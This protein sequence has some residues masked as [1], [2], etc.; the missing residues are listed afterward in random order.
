MTLAAKERGG[1]VLA[2][3]ADAPYLCAMVLVA[4]GDFAARYAEAVRRVVRAI[5]DEVDAVAK[6]PLQSAELLGTVGPSLGDPRA[7]IVADPPARLADN[8]SFFGIGGDTPVRYTELYQSAAGLWVK[9]KEP[10]DPF[11]PAESVDLTV[12]K[13]VV[14]AA[15]ERKAGEGR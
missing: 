6:D 14:R 7:A 1:K 4:R 3:T 5:F 10:G 2:T 13:A 11:P 9:L 15:D 12:I 8:V